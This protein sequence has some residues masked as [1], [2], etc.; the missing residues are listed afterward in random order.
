MITQQLGIGRHDFVIICSHQLQRD[1]EM[2]EH[3]IPRRPT[4]IG[5]LGSQNRIRTLFEG[6]AATANV[7]APVGLA[8]E[9]EG[10]EEIAV[11]IAAELVSV[12]ARARDEGVEGV[13]L[14]ENSRNIFGG[15]G[16][17]ENGGGESF[18]LELS[19]GITL[20]SRGL[21]EMRA[22]GL[23]SLTVVV[24]KEDTLLWVYDRKEITGNRLSKIESSL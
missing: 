13:R 21:R 7:H 11:S 24:R 5:V 9:A 23:S 14:D 18:P 4:Y 12:R 16:K 3:A 2:I 1:R 10:P 20:G 15:R 22:C 6:I 19:P 17:P 8:I